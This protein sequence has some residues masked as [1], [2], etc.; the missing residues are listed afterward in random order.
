LRG[1]RGLG[2]SYAAG[3]C[4]CDDL[5]TLVRIAARAVR[6]SRVNTLLTEAPIRA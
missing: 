6:G 4:D 3:A 1:S 2:E 5:V